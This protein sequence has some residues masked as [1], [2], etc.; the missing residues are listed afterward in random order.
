MPAKLFFIPLLIALILTGCSKSEPAAVAVAPSGPRTI[1]ITAGDNMKYS[2]TRIE[3]A[4]GEALHVT[5]TNT[6]ALPK[7]VMGHD[8]ILLRAG[9]DAE[10][11]SRA[12]IAAKDTNYQPPSLAFEVLASIS[13]L[14]P[15]Q[16]GDV[17]FNAPVQPGEYPFLCSFPAHCQSGMQGVLVVR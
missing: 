11:Y 5:L 17:T 13:L 7:E 15:G 12:A 2:L 1:E 8:W 9:A 4:S 10:A 6:G 3:A 16:T 14:G